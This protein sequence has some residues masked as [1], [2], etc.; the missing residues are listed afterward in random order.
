VL[1]EA[2]EEGAAEAAVEL[3]E[4]GRR[5]PLHVAAEWF[6]ELAVALAG[7]GLSAE[8]DAI[9]ESV[10]TATPWREGGLALGRGDAPAA[11]A[12]FG[13]M[14]ARP[15]EAEAH[16]L[17]AQDGL[18]ADLPAAIALV[19]IAIVVLMVAA[20]LPAVQRDLQGLQLYGWNFAALTLAS[21]GAVPV[22]GDAARDR[23]R[24]GRVRTPPVARPPFRSPSFRR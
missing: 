11:A 5:A 16:L 24:V 13:Q 9:A 20:I 19:L 4:L 18:P 17:A 22:A 14:G 12:I 2:D 1:W 6:P 15:L 3:A 7:L 8:L 23:H 21:F 10:P